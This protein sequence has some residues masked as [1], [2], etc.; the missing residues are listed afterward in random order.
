[1]KITE[2]TIKRVLEVSLESEEPDAILAIL[3]EH[4]GKP[5][6]KRILGKLPG[7]EESWRLTHAYGMTHLE[8]WTYCRTSGKDGFHFLLA[9]AEKN[10]VL[11]TQFFVER[12]PSYF[13]G[14]I[15][16]NRE[17]RNALGRPMAC[18]RLADRMNAVQAARRALQKAEEEMETVVQA[19]F[20]ADRYDWQVLVGEDEAKAKVVRERFGIT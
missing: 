4:E 17:R 8:T 16:R 10:V 19:G 1:M 7:G 12:N 20:T 14:R 13:E 9:H 11:D 18:D 15:E 6:T 5:L 2:E 3:K